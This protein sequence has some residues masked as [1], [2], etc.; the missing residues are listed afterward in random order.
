VSFP[1]RGCNG[2]ICPSVVKV[3]GGREFLSTSDRILVTRLV[4]YASE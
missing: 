1:H 2:E 3:G 4:V